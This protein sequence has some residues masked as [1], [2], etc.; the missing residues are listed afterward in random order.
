MTENANIETLFVHDYIRA[1]TENGDIGGGFKGRY[2]T[3]MSF[4]SITRF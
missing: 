1:V 2:K 4:P 3:T